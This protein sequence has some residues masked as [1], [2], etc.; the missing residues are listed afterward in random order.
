MTQ[1]DIDAGSV[2]NHASAT[3]TPASGTL[4]PATDEATADATQTP[5]LTIDKTS[6]TTEV[7]AVGQVVP[8][9]YTVRNTGNVALSGLTLADDNTDAVPV[10]PVTSLAPG[11]STTCTA[12]HTVTQADL[13]GGTT[14]HNTVTASTGQG[15]GATDNLAIPIVVTPGLVITKTST[16]TMFSAVGQSIEYTMTATN[17]G[18]VTLTGVTVSDPGIAT[19]ACTPAQPATLAPGATMT[20]TGSH[21]ITQADVTAGK[22]TNTATVVGHCGEAEP[23]SAESGPVVITFE[24][25]PVPP[26]EA[27]AQAIGLGP[28]GSTMVGAVAVALL[29]LLALGLLFVIPA[30]RLGRRRDDP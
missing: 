29:A 21:V 11:A 16:S 27:I 3:G 20:C 5:A 28:G 22:Y 23:V 30:G 25:V 10:C 2:T 17:T 18:N 14:L 6:T 12:V 1:A 7:T 9:S 8:Y 19:L 24:A 13:D 15:A 26:T 4:T